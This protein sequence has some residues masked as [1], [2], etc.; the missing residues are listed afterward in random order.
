MMR[1]DLP[2]IATRPRRS[3]IS[4]LVLVGE[5]LARVDRKRRIG[6]QHGVA[7][8]ILVDEVGGVVRDVLAP[9]R[10]RR[11]I[12]REPLDDVQLGAMS[13]GSGQAAGLEGDSVHDE[14]IAVP[15][16]DRMPGAARRDP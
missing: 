14:R 11:G 8:D 3:R 13:D 5:L 9:Q 7:A 15:A 1:F 2:L 10:E 12:E 4:R 6:R 16:A